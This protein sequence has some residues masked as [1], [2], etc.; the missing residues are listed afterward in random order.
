[1]RQPPRADPLSRARA[2]GAAIE[3]AADEIERRRRLVPDVLD[4]LHE[5]RLSRMFAPRAAGGD[6]TPP[7]AAIAAIEEISRHDASVGWN[8]FVANAAALIAPYL[9]AET[10]RAVFGGSRAL[11][12]WGPPDGQAIAAVPGGYRVNGRWRFASGCRHA[13]W[14]G[15]HGRVIEP[16]GETRRDA[17]GA[18][19]VLTALFPAE[20]A[21]LLDDWNAIGLRGTGSESYRVDDVFVPESHTGLRGDPAR[22]RE[23][24][25]LYAFTMQGLYA[26]GVA[27]VA[28][29]VAR[30]MLDD[31]VALAARKAPRGLDRLADR[32]VF[33]AVIARA[34]AR[35]GAARAWLRETLD[36]IYAR[37][38]VDAPI[39]VADRARVRLAA[40]HAIQAAIDVA[41]RVWREAGVDAIFPGGPFERRFR[42][43]HTLSQQLQSREAHYERVGRVLL[44]DPP[45]DFL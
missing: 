15:A 5:T 27:A 21:T 29:G 2:L 28:L 44:G 25:R 26:A 18:P 34:E 20:Q 17:A 19:V 45:A 39:G 42:D 37:A 22:Q 43:I 31:L 24:G 38:G 16:D 1:M 12:A 23:P 32:P 41:H 33:R 14:M 4:K 6:E 40:T 13:T 35:I 30:A 9:P 3:A 8:L 36:E 7:A 11:V 10:A